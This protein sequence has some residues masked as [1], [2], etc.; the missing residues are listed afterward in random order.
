[1]IK[2][3]HAVRNVYARI[4]PEPTSPERKKPRGNNHEKILAFFLAFSFRLRQYLQNRGMLNSFAI[5]PILIIATVFALVGCS[6]FSNEPEFA[7]VVTEQDS[8]NDIPVASKKKMICPTNGHL[9][10]CIITSVK[11]PITS[12]PDWH[13]APEPEVVTSG[14]TPGKRNV[15]TEPATAAPQTPSVSDE[16][17]AAITR[18]LRELISTLEPLIAGRSNS[19]PSPHSG[20]GPAHERVPPSPPGPNDATMRDRVPGPAPSISGHRHPATMPPPAAASLI[21]PEPAAG[22]RRDPQA[23]NADEASASLSDKPFSPG[24][25]AEG[26]PSSPPAPQPG[27]AT[28]AR[29]LLASVYFPV[30][31]VTLM[32]S[33]QIV[34]IDL[35]PQ[36]SGKRL[37]FVGFTDRTGDK[38]TNVRLAY[39]RARAV[40]TFFLKTGLDPANLFAAAKG[41]CCYKNEGTTP[42]GR[43]QN[44]RVEIH[45]TTE[46]FHPRPLTSE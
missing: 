17:H 40:K 18:E 4:G 22:S 27:K 5:R 45:E 24:G 39:R 14:T 31:S 30:N 28:P 37:L 10:P 38:D 25:Q 29:R 23:R 15:P 1:M 44:R 21:D 9:Y 2:T 36:V 3:W 26:A 35:L 6:Q 32:P 46:T 11:T 16:D 13:A 33:E 19:R 42:T 7:R 41:P 34:L 12:G 8:G 20:A 43:Q